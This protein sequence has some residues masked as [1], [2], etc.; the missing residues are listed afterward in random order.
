MPKRNGADLD[1]AQ[2][3]TPV[4]TV[5]KGALAAGQSHR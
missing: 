3:R 2:Y 5:N 4:S 1:I